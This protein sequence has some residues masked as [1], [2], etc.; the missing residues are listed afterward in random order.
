MKCNFQLRP[1][2]KSIARRTLVGCGIALIVIGLTI[3]AKGQHAATDRVPAISS[4]P[5]ISV[6]DGSPVYGAGSIVIRE[7]NSVFAS[8]HSTGL[9]PGTAVSGWLVVINSPRNCS[10]RPCSEADAGDPATQS[11]A[12]NFGGRVV[13]VD[14]AVDLAEWRAAGDT[15]NA[16][17]GPG[18][19]N[20]SGAEVQ[21]V[22]RSHGPASTDPAI[23]QQQLTTFFGGCPPNACTSLQISVHPPR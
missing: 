2:V 13:G 23:L 4:Q 21:M 5:V 7:K 9:A 14:G 6:S 17:F 16:L 1:F 15:T 10:I 12:F 8:I 18:L 3:T 11:A 20:S 19:L 22:L